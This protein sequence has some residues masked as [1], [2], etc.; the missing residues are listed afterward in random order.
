[1]DRLDAMAVFRTVAELGGLAAAARRLN[2]SPAAVTRAIA[3]LEAR[4]GARLLTRTTRRVGLTDAGRAYLADCRR[5]LAEID[6]AEAAASGAHAIAKGE[7]R[8]TAPTQFGRL[9]LGPALPDFLQAYPELTVQVLLVDRIVDLVEEGIDVGLR[10]GALASTALVALRLGSVRRV[11]VGSP[12]Y[13]STAGRPMSP[14]DLAHHR[15]IAPTSLMSAANW[16]F[17]VDGRPRLVPVRARLATSQPD[18]AID[19]ARAGFG[20][21]QVPLYQVA[22]DLRTGRLEIVL[23]AFEEAPLPVSIVTVDGRRAAAKVRA[24]VAFM[25]PR[26][27]T[28]LL[29]LPA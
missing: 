28:V 7:L 21:T 1:M 19:A 8:V 11:V 6:E 25:T 12:A 3:A 17:V 27:R 2:L 26:L 14:D 15:L 10:I 29:D 9:Y 16:G 23:E 24:F 20:L 13:L 5:I 22:E 18:V 4:L